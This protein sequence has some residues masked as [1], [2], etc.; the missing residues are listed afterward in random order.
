MSTQNKIQVLRTPEEL[1][2]WHTA[3]RRADKRIG[4]VP[5]MGALHDGH[6]SLVKEAQK[7][8]DSV[9]ASIFVNPTQFAPNEDFDSYPRTLDSDLEKLEA[10]GC[11]AAYCP[12]ARDL[13]PEGDATK[14]YVEGLSSILEGEHR[15]HFFGGVTNIVSRLFIHVAPDVA[16]FGQKD[17][18]QLMII[19]R[20]VKDLGMAVKILG[21]PTIREKDGLAMSSRNQYLSADERTKAGSFAGALRK[22]ASSIEAGESIKA[23]I[24]QALKDIT[25]AGLGPINYVA[26]RN[27]D[28]LAPLESDTLEKGTN[29]RILTAAWMGKTRLIDNLPLER[30]K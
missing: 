11:C 16:V 14:V 9:I 15:P 22:A 10:A 21:A 2:R 6:V 17:Y 19:K 29:A 3:Q 26:V 4:F 23:S 18:Q 5:T 7:H 1:R 25:T 28:T 8:A 24:D 27:A 30:K 20:M 13:Y 12:V